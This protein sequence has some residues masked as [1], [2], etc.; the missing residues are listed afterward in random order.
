MNKIITQEQ[1]ES[2]LQVFRTTNISMA[3]GEA[4]VRFFENLPSEN[5]PKVVSE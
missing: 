5:K 4:I 2:V 3:N 1:I